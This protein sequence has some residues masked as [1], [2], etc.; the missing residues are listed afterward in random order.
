M[1]CHL[2]HKYSRLLIRLI[3]FHT[4]QLLTLSSISLLKCNGCFEFSPS[5][6][7]LHVIH[8]KFHKLT[9]FQRQSDLK[10]R[11]TQVNRGASKEGNIF[12]NSFSKNSYVALIMPQDR[13]EWWLSRWTPLKGCINFLSRS[14]RIVTKTFEKDWNSP[15]IQDCMEVFTTLIGKNKDPSVAPNSPPQIKSLTKWVL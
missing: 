9:Y 7:V 5:F 12:H 10:C 3:T 6:L 15:P 11:N 1:Y 14:S 13:T 8:K 4:K 2:L